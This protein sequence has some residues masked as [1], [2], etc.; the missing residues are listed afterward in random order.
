MWILFGLAATVKTVNTICIST[1]VI[2]SRSA[3][4]ANLLKTDMPAELI[5]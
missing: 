3:D 4:T 5:M 1:S 2:G